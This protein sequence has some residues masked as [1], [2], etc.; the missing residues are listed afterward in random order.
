MNP[1]LALS[2]IIAAYDAYVQKR[3]DQDYLSKAIDEGRKFVRQPIK[4]APPTADL[5]AKS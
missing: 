4:M 3:V 2:N 5:G 1:M